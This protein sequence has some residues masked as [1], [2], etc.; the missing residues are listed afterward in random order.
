MTS[1]WHFDFYRFRTHFWITSTNINLCSLH[2][3]LGPFLHKRTILS[4]M[5]GTEDL[6]ISIEERTHPFSCG[7]LTVGSFCAWVRP[8]HSTA[9]ILTSGRA[10]LKVPHPLT[11]KDAPMSFLLCLCA[12]LPEEKVKNSK[13]R[14]S[15]FAA[16]FRESR[17]LHSHL[18]TKSS[19]QS[20]T[21]Q[22]STFEVTEPSAVSNPMQRRGEVVKACSLSADK[23]EESERRKPV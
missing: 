10:K 14:R 19:L 15:R 22:P 17:A 23:C 18:Q 16:S 2:I 1:R 7:I 3:L 11:K 13:G 21:S 12:C 4:T 5:G 9:L 20:A 6:S 8:P